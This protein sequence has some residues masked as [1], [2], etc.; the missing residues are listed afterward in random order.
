[1]Q[2][3]LKLYTPVPAG[4]EREIAERLKHWRALREKTMKD[5]G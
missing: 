3:A 2:K 5:G 1:M 4:A